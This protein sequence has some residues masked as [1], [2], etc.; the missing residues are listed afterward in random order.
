MVG[1][2]INNMI[3]YNA[4]FTFQMIIRLL[5]FIYEILVNSL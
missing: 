4:I 2:D 1:N 5:S 3:L